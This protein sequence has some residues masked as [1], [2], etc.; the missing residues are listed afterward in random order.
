VRRV[1]RRVERVVVHV[2]A[3]LIEIDP[4]RVCDR[5][6]EH[7]PV[8]RADREVRRSPANSRDCRRVPLVEIPVAVTVE[9]VILLPALR[10]R[11]RSSRSYRFVRVVDPVQRP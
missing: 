6:I 11:R 7:F 10:S 4:V 8:G 3:V 1:A 9:R 2:V 5:R